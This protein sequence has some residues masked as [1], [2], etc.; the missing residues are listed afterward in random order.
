MGFVPPER[1]LPTLPH[2]TS[3]AGALLTDRHDRPLLLTSLHPG[4]Y[5][6]PGGPLDDEDPWTCALRET[7]GETGFVP[8]ALDDT[9]RPAS[10][11]PRSLPSA[12]STTCTRRLCSSPTSTTSSARPTGAPS[13][14]AAP[15]RPH[16]LAA[17]TP[18]TCPGR[19][20]PA[21]SDITLRIPRGQV[22]ALAGNNGS[23]K[24]TLATT[25]TGLRLPDTGRMLWD[26]VDAETADRDQLFASAAV[27][28][29]GFQQ[30][31]LTPTSAGRAFLDEARDL[32]KRP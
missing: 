4:E 2:G 17:D 22:V 18:F 24:S 27:L 11:P 8:A 12:P 31:P 15:T 21:L 25:L 30:S 6:Y 13:P 1:F 5:Q 26:G 19:T 32:L 29:Q 10:A 7:A 9:P 14:P 28:E 16:H 3:H 20:N 23:G